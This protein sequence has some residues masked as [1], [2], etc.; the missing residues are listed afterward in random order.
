L[1]PNDWRRNNPRFQG[2]QF[3]RNLAIADTIGEIAREKGVTPA[4]LAL[5][6]VLAQGEDVI[7]IPGTSSVQRLEENHRSIDV[8]LTTDE[9]KRL[10]QVAPKGA[11]AGDRYEPGMMHLLN[12]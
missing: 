10:D 7:P 5:A 12:G 6:W 4:Q 2:E 11:A 9:L 8:V 3:Q 1:A